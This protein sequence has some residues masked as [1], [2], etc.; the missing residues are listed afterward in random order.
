MEKDN[1]ICRLHRITK[2]NKEIKM[3]QK[4]REEEDGGF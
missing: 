3:L 4:S 2:E 1:S